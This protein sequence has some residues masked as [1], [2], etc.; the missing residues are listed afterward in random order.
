MSRMQADSFSRVNPRMV[1][2]CIIYVHL[3]SSMKWWFSKQVTII[4]TAHILLIEAFLM[5]RKTIITKSDYNCRIVLIMPTYSRVEPVI[6]FWLLIRIAWYLIKAKFVN[7]TNCSACSMLIFSRLCIIRTNFAF[8]WH[9]VM[10]SL[11]WLWIT[12]FTN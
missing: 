2:F 12:M 9:W 6:L 5:Q 1:G 7:F 3:W 4:Q 8:L 11:L 10:H